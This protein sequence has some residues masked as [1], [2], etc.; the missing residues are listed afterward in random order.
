MAAVTVTV[1]AAPWEPSK[2]RAAPPS[3]LGPCS[4]GRLE[5][6]PLPRLSCQCINGIIMITPPRGRTVGVGSCQ[7]ATAARSACGCRF[8]R[9]GGDK[10][11]AR[12]SA[13]ALACRPPR[14]LPGAGQP[15]HMVCTWGPRW[16]SAESVQT[17]TRSKDM[18]THAT[19]GIRRY[20]DP[21]TVED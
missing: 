2:F 17:L 13:A 1:T 4:F 8:E 12:S 6:Q 10:Q 11:E 15:A 21:P 20:F 18:A 19:S 14:R 3:V 16:G 5:V 7:R 9:A